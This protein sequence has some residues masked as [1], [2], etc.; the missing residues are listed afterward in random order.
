MLVENRFIFSISSNKP[1]KINWLGVLKLG[2]VTLDF[3][4]SRIVNNLDNWIRY[5]WH[6]IGFIF[7]SLLK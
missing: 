5:T 7:G 6:A 1:D 2:G 4:F 3:S